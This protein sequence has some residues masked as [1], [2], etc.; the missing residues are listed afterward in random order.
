MNHRS[1]YRDGKVSHGAGC[2]EDYSLIIRVPHF[3]MDLAAPVQ[4]VVHVLV[5]DMAGDVA[6]SQV[7]EH[8]LQRDGDSITWTIILVSV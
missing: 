5:E 2:I 1:T 3:G 8:L 6:R 7:P 4:D